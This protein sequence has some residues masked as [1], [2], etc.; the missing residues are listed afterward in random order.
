MRKL[1]AYILFGIVLVA[2]V[3]G[4]FV[5]I[6]T[7]MNL[8]SEFSSGKGF[9]YQ[10]TDR[11]D[12]DPD[13]GNLPSEEHFTALDEGNVLNVAQTF[14]D[15]LNNSDINTYSVTV[16]GERTIRM[17]F[18]TDPYKYDFISKYVNFNPTFTFT[19]SNAAVDFLDAS[20]IM[21]NGAKAEM[22]MH[23][24]I[25]T[26]TLPIDT[27]NEKWKAFFDSAKTIANEAKV[28]EQQQ[29]DEQEP[30]MVKRSEGAAT[31]EAAIFIWNNFDANDTLQKARDSSDP[32]IGEKVFAVLPWG[33]N[34]DGG[35]L[36][37]PD[38]N[39]NKLMFHA[40]S[41]SLSGLP[42]EMTGN[43]NQLTFATKWMVNMFNASNFKFGSGTEQV[44]YDAHLL[45][46]DLDPNNILIP[47]TTEHLFVLGDHVT[48][49]AST[50]LW[51][52]LIMIVLLAALFGFFFR[53][54]AVATQTLTLASAFFTFAL[55]VAFSIEFN[56]AAIIGLIVSVLA[57]AVGQVIYL[58][59]LKK[60]FKDGKTLKKAHQEA[61]RKSTI[62][63]IDVGV[64][65]IIIGVIFLVL[66]NAFLLPFSIM[67]IVGGF[68]NTIF[69]VFGLRLMLSIV[70]GNASYQEKPQLFNLESPS[71]SVETTDSNEEPAK[72]ETGKLPRKHFKKSI[73]ISGALLVAGIV[74]L[75]VFAG[76][77]DGN[78]LNNGDMFVENSRLTLTI[79]NKDNSI[80]DRALITTVLNR[81]TVD[82]TDEVITYN[83]E[84]ERYQSSELIQLSDDSVT[85]LDLVFYVIQFNA[86]YTNETLV[87]Y[88]DGTGSPI[89]NENLITVL[90]DAFDS[91]ATSGADPIGRPLL[92]ID[93]QV[94]A[95]IPGQP[96][97]WPVIGAMLLAVL[98]VSVYIAARYRPSRGIA[99]LL[100]TVA[101]AIIPIAVVSIAQIP[102][103][104]L[105]LLSVVIIAVV[106][107]LIMLLFFTLEKDSI[108][109][110]KVKRLTM[111]EK[112]EVM[113]ESVDA[114]MVNGVVLYLAIAFICGAFLFAGPI[115]YMTM[116]IVSVLGAGLLGAL[117][118][119]LLV[120]PL[121]TSI[122]KL[123]FKIWASLPKGDPN[124]KKKKISRKK[125]LNLPEKS[126]EPTEAV[127]IGI[128]DAR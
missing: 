124:K 16:D 94:V 80:D 53:L 102:T 61:A 40:T 41:Y 98:L 22:I 46:S 23:E 117:L 64:I 73:I 35:S 58:T 10:I 88:D 113:Y 127:F 25:P 52:I 79:R 28:L 86:Q 82:E 11:V 21:P 108:I 51:S 18:A 15:R 90:Q 44:T 38:G 57:M 101:T 123:F 69:N 36:W 74:G 42:Q 45:F 7:S 8:G 75:S 24:G 81:I 87:S 9:V 95:S 77:N 76:L 67:M 48:I 5:P 103:S 70:M 115:N 1:I 96:E 47:P 50:I 65:Q 60:E 37:Y 27:E 104:P 30:M 68:L 56:V 120:G 71:D 125:Q 59:K 114:F 26:I 110:K 118:T 14:R 4:L 6:A 55:F 66:G 32:R 99:S 107:Q 93:L 49:K 128:N 34:A 39:Q 17:E 105:V 121:G 33:E 122:N 12:R 2:T 19:T 119:I 126:A 29:A 116:F 106:T 43:R 100:V 112:K 13:T 84:F 3:A 85:S 63:M 91:E 92:A 89:A 54:S 83:T 72:V 111:S 62:P 31:P 78:I 20:E 109:D 97:A